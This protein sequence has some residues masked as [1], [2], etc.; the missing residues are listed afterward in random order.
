MIGRE[1][2]YMYA[3]VIIYGVLIQSEYLHKQV[4]INF[5]K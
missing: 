4:K 1:E 3:V 5:F 2:V